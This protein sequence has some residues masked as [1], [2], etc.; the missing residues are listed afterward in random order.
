MKALVAWCERH[1]V[2][3]F[4]GPVVLFLSCFAL[5]ATGYLLYLSLS[6]WNVAN[7]SPVFAGLANFIELMKDGQ[8]WKSLFRTGVYV[9]GSV[10]CEL[11]LGMILALLLSQNLPG[12]GLIR[13]LFLLPMAVTPAVAGL[14]WRI[15]Y[16][17]TLG[18]INHLLSTIGLRGK[19][20]VADAHTAL[21]ALML[22]DVWQWTPF[23]ML[24]LL[25]GLQALPTE[26]F[27]AARVD[28]ASRFQSFVYLT[29]PMLK[30]VMLV[31][32]LLRGI[33]AF[34][35]FDTIFVITNGGPGTSTQTVTFFAYQE[36]FGWFNLGYAS[37]VA[38]VLLVLVTV[39]VHYFQKY[40]RMKVA[41]AN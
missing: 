1:I 24:I 23:V 12:T 7:P 35:A 30:Q 38:I 25:A 9:A 28:G 32:V 39:L 15:L 41:Q 2:L 29:M 11:V 18:L 3:V 5:Y 19:A 14:V 31:T 40:T 33:D 8:F 16:D 22:V 17:P 13:T 37:A 27:E 10:S 34:K 36:G 21:P 4:V 6:H 26:P 20:W